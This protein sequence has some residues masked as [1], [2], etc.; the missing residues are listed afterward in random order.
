MTIERNFGSRR[1][2]AMV[3]EDGWFVAN[4]RQPNLVC[5]ACHIS[6][7]DGAKLRGACARS[8]NPI[9]GRFPS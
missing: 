8:A 1:G 5:R 3:L 7:G 9:H 4:R 6:I 2:A